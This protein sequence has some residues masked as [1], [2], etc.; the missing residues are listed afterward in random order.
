MWHALANSAKLRIETEV[1][2]T[3]EFDESNDTGKKISGGAA[4]SKAGYL[5]HPAA[6]V[7]IVVDVPINPTPILSCDAARPGR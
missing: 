7:V 6:A 2:Q 4:E 1:T 3:A 5:S